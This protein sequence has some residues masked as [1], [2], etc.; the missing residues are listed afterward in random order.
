MMKV[1]SNGV[2]KKVC[3][4]C[5]GTGISRAF[6]RHPKYSEAVRVQAATLWDK[7]FSLR[8]IAAK[9]H[10]KHPQTVKNLLI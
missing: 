5:N 4:R 10:L 2:K 9:L 3:P 8:E 7:G 1:I 6:N